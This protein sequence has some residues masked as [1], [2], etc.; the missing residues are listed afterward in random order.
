MNKEI[1]K[2]IKEVIK[3]PMKNAGFKVDGQGY[4]RVVNGIICQ[5]FDFQGSM[6]GEGFTINIGVNP[7]FDKRIN[8]V[9]DFRNYI[10]IGNLLLKG[11]IWWSY[12]EET[13]KEVADII[14]DKLLP[15]FEQCSTFEGMLS[16]YEGLISVC[17]SENAQTPI[18][19]AVISATPL[20]YILGE[21]IRTENDELA[22][23]F[24]KTLEDYYMQKTED[25]SPYCDEMI[26]KAKNDE[27]KQYWVQ[28]KQRER[29]HFEDLTVWWKTQTGNYLSQDKTELL[30]KMEDN[31]KENC[32]V[33]KKFIK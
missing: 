17:Q 31:E 25:P 9:R 23:G 7:L 15:F 12:T 18:A 30:E 5:S 20:N 11:D 21:C 16:F 3:S 22:S 13:V 29:Q 1:I 10:R 4:V 24:V 19:L 2:Q 28:Q 6:S 32:A 27:E 26:A 14:T 33:L 8:A